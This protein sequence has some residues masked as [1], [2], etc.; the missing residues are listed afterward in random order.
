MPGFI[1]RAGLADAV[2]PLDS[3][4]PQILS[5]FHRELSVAAPGR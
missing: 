4:V 1:V 5:Q 3:V 2:V